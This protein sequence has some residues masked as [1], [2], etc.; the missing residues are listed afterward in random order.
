MRQVHA[1]VLAFLVV[2]ACSIPAYA[3][4]GSIVGVVLD[5]DGKP[6]GGATVLIERAE[7]GQRFEL[8]TDNKGNYN[9]QGVDDGVYRVSVIQNGAPIAANNAVVSLGF[10]VDL[11]FDLRNQGTSPRSTGAISRAQ[12]EAEQRANTETQGAFNAGLTA[13]NSGNYDEAAKQFSL[14]AE[15]KP[16][17]PVIFAR[18]GET[19][20]GAKKYGEAA[21]A[22]KKATELK[23]DEADYFDNLG[24]AA[25]RAGK[26][27]M[28]TP[29]IQK[30]VELDPARGELAFRN[31]GI[32][33]AE[34]GQ[35]KEAIEA[36]QRSIKQNPKGADSYYQLGLVYMKTPATM[37]DSVT[38]FEKYLQLAPKG[39]HAA[40]AKE[41]VAITKAS[42]PAR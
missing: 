21:D 3:Q 40:T 35:D 10:R 39:E 30:A 4:S 34:R 32:L 14:A 27:D 19:Y 9:K 2:M 11:N 25:S 20:M 7:V 5:R 1:R 36:F 41:L 12:R 38:Q 8:K 29:A 28:A 16:N 24:A 6:I 23:A 26:F 15:R 22:Y 31:L 42:A 33:L 13:L 18:L 17:L 37:A